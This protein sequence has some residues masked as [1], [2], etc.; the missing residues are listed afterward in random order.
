VEQVSLLALMLMSMIFFQ[1]DYLVSAVM[2]VAWLGSNLCI[3]E[4]KTG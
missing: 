3:G 2:R 4:M 1:V